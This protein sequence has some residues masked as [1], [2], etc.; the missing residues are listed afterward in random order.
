M[1]LCMKRGDFFE[2]TGGLRLVEPPA[3]REGRCLFAMYPWEKPQGP[4]YRGN[5]EG[6]PP[7]GN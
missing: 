4:I 6:L 3:R 1:S 7:G 2:V 5:A